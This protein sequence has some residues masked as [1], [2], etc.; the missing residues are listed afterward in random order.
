[1]PGRTHTIIPR[2]GMNKDLSPSK[3]TAGHYYHALNVRVSATDGANLLT[4]ATEKGNIAIPVSPSI[5]GS[6]LGCLVVDKY[7]VL[8]VRDLLSATTIYRL[9]L[10]G[11]NFVS[12]EVLK[13]DMGHDAETIIEAV[14]VYE[15]ADVIKVY[16]TDGKHPLAFVNIMKD[17]LPYEQEYSDNHYL[18]S[19]DIHL[20]QEITVTR[21]PAG[22][23]FHSGNTQYFFSYW[24]V[25]GQESRIFAAT[26]VYCNTVGDRAGSPDET[27]TNS[28]TIKIKDLDSD[29]SN[30][31]RWDYLRV[32]SI[33]R[34]T[35][36]VVSNCRIVAD[37]KVKGRN[38][39][40]EII[41][42]DTGAGSSFDSEA[43]LF[44]GA[45]VFS[46]GTL[47][48]KDNTLFIGNITPSDRGDV[49]A[50]QEYLVNNPV[51]F[52]AAQRSIQLPLDGKTIRHWKFG[53]TYRIGLQGQ[54]PTGEWSPPF[55]LG[56]DVTV[57]KGFEVTPEGPTANSPGSVYY[58]VLEMV[59]T[60]DNEA[61]Y[62]QLHELLAQHNVTRVRPVYVPLSHHNRH[63]LSQGLVLDT[64][65]NVGARANNGTYAYADWLARPNMDFVLGRR[66]LNM[67][68]T[69]ENSP[70]DYA[71]NETPVMT[72]P[73]TPLGFSFHREG[74]DTANT[75][76]PNSIPWLYYY[77]AGNVTPSLSKGFYSLNSILLGSNSNETVSSRSMYSENYVRT[78]PPF[79]QSG[80]SFIIEPFLN[81]RYNP[82]GQTNTVNWS[83]YDP[84]AAGNN[85]DNDRWKFSA[86]TLA[87][88][89]FREPAVMT[90]YSPETVYGEL[91]R[92]A[93]RDVKEIRL[94]GITN[95]QYSS[96]FGRH[97]ISN[98]N[99]WKY[100]RD[101][102]AENAFNMITTYDDYYWA[103]DDH[104]QKITWGT[105]GPKVVM[106]KEGSDHLEFIYRAQSMY[107]YCNS[108]TPLKRPGQMYIE[109]L[110]M[111]M[112]E[113]SAVM[114]T[115]PLSKE[116]LVI[117]NPCPE[118]TLRDLPK[119]FSW[120][121][122]YRSPAHFIFSLKG[123][124]EARST[125]GLPLLGVMNYSDA[126]SSNISFPSEYY[127]DN[128][129]T[130]LPGWMSIAAHA[131]RCIDA[132]LLQRDHSRCVRYTGEDGAKDMMTLAGGNGGYPYYWI[133]DLWQE[134]TNQYGPD[135]SLDS[136]RQ[137]RWIPAGESVPLGGSWGKILFDRGDTYIQRFDFLKS[138][139]RSTANADQWSRFT[140]GASTW[141]ESFIN[142]DGRYDKWKEQRDLTPFTYDS[143]GKVNSAYTQLDN[144]FEYQIPDSDL[145]KTRPMPASF[146]WSRAKTPGEL[147]DTYTKFRLLTNTYTV[148]GSR[149]P[150]NRL[151]NVNNDIIAFQDSA[152]FQVLFNA[153]VQV[154]VSD[155]I[156]VELSQGYKVEGVRYISNIIG[157]TNKW[158]I[159]LSN[160]A[161]YFV[162]E[163]NR[164][165][166]VLGNPILNLSERA[167]M[168]TW[169]DEKI[170][171]EGEKKIGDKRFITT[172][173]TARDLV[174]FINDE[175]ALCYNENLGIFEGF[176][177]HEGKELFFN[178]M[179][180][181]YTI[182]KE[183]M[184]DNAHLVIYRNHAGKPAYLYGSYRP[185]SITLVLNP[186]PLVDKTWDS[187]QYRGNRFDDDGR[188]I[189]DSTVD[190]IEAWNDYQRALVPYNVLT[191]NLPGLM[192]RPAYLFHHK[193]Q[194]WNIPFPRQE[195]SLN[196]LRSPWLYLKLDYD[197]KEG[198][199]YMNMHDITIKYTI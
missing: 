184:Y 116:E 120:E 46:V 141:I 91:G 139:P 40:E 134:V 102:V 189:R 85:T 49:K 72:L 185:S 31:V 70:T 14:G 149:G 54:Y 39:S 9:H 183:G 44:I 59:D 150:V 97:S 71:Y 51:E 27:C 113:D 108:V 101:A 192:P 22:G 172:V 32:Y 73:Y 125:L 171:R 127:L 109:P 163:L 199:S 45:D 157:S 196:R 50:I 162:D 68:H 142:L 165:I 56:K 87:N 155:G 198:D 2:E 156:P 93:A 77:L 168:K 154:P 11:D 129:V 94:R 43:L 57:D 84:A 64:V 112:P 122:N 188:I 114:I 28:Y 24:N 10:D 8:F 29:K 115:N 107:S 148:E 33:E 62:R 126:G 30:L 186:D 89:F 132:S 177:S 53:E 82:Y 55:W 12:K 83:N 81:T 16:F 137:L 34:S 117:Y 86:N 96:Y 35:R 7:I 80:D 67:S 169:S 135:N 42:T 69:E 52:R 194:T 140:H 78:A 175:Q 105:F 6:C 118:E 161:L 170:A 173:D 124:S 143:W 100:N 103:H 26:D 19:P 179:G 138:Y 176:Y 21:N 152:I 193:F 76:I 5:E 66:T 151:V 191:G 60:P 41:I 38:R 63:V 25:N 195:N 18:I 90:F 123:N 74:M 190:A 178:Y 92:D 130:G 174:Y 181:N 136:L 180:D 88:A 98:N 65:G 48:T 159:A 13:R 133:A 3:Y 131:V 146:A 121:V 1:M 145:L 106:D 166:R 187:I 17:Y 164:D 128:N 58:T 36:D 160:R 147:I 104:H 167:G 110:V 75:Y 153:R 37:V 158:S 47:A 15:N 99:S 23:I 20:Y 144:F 61:R 111:A 79:N 182:V 119:G 95:I 4:L 197:N